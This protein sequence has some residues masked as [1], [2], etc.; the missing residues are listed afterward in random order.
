LT[1]LADEGVAGNTVEQNRRWREMIVADVPSA[2]LAGWDAFAP[3]DGTDL[4]EIEQ[5]VQRLL[6]LGGAVIV[7]HVVQA[8]GSL[9][10]PV[11]ADCGKPMEVACRRARQREGLVGRYRLPRTVYVCRH[12]D[13]T[14]VPADE[15]W[16][17]G[18]GMLSPA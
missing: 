1:S 15:S 11:C 7:E 5:C 8:A 18:P 10:R 6:R 16:G 12:C 13:R 14:A 17:L 9:P 2:L 4:E 3:E